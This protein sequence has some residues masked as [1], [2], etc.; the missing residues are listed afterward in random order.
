M[1]RLPVTAVACLSLVAGSAAAAG[2]GSNDE[3]T[4]STPPKSVAAAA[5]QAKPATGDVV[6]VTMKNIKFLPQS[7]TAKVGQKIHWTNKDGQIP[8]TVTATK[9]AIFDS[10]NVDGGA[11]FDYTPTKAG[12]IDYVCTIHS[13]QTG[14][15]TVTR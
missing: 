2:C 6:E 3:K 14:S 13:G 1:P 12:R 5:P 7:I 9:G 8:H 15:I 11:T 4:A 10:G